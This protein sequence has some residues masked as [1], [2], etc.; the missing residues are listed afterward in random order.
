MIIILNLLF[1]SVSIKLW[2]L[3]FLCAR[4]QNTCAYA[5]RKTQLLS[6]DSSVY[7]CVHRTQSAYMGMYM[8]VHL[9]GYENVLVIFFKQFIHSDG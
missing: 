1:R 5:E 8:S 3:L 6:S 4:P 7:E 2:V 9:A